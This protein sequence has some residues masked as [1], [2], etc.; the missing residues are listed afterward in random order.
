[1]SACVCGTSACVADEAK[2]GCEFPFEG[3]VCGFVSIEA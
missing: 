1:M 3:K 2:Q